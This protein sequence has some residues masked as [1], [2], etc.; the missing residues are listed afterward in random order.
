MEHYKE[1]YFNWQK[2]IGA[3]GGKA[4]LFKFREHINPEYRILDFGSGGGFLLA[5]IEA[6]E[7]IGIE[8]NE[9][10]R[11]QANEQG[12]TTVAS[13]DEIEDGW[14]DLVISNHALEHV[15]DPL[16]EIRRLRKKIKPGGKIVLV[17]PYEK[18]NRY[19]ANDINFHL[20]TWSEMNLG[21]LF[22]L[23]GY[24]IEDV[25]EIK[26]RWPPNFLKIHKLFGESIFN[27]VCKFYGLL[28]SG[29]ISQVR[30]IARNP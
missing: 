22:T 14:A 3:F 2:N 30:I 10:A 1:D 20:F 9:T 12:I 13:P 25:S 5:N 23:A 6:K 18:K 8:I 17:V 16:M 21:N 19:K 24:E 7:K 4:N 28:K 26:H 11:S 27:S 15:N 29:S